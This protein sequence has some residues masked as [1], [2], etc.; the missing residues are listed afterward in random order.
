MFL[1]NAKLTDVNELIELQ[2]LSVDPILFD[3][4][5]FNSFSNA[6]N[7]SRF[8]V[9]SENNKIIAYSI[10]EKACLAMKKYVDISCENIIV[11]RFSGTVLHPE[12]KGKGI[13][14]EFLTSHL[15]YCREQQYHK[16]MAMVHP[17]N[18]ASKKNIEK[19]GLSYSKREYISE[20]NGYRDIY[21]MRINNF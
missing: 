9:L 5:D 4:R 7:E 12:Y 8:L 14:K 18:I 2:E 19:T 15:N 17:D 6:I 21:K 11:G 16:I 1:R 13:Q 20:K 3:K 10:M